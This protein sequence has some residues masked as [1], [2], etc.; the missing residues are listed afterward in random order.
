VLGKLLVLFITIPLLEMLILIKMGEAFGFW[1]TV[2]LVIVTGFI[3]AVLARIE[4][5]RTWLAIR[6]ELRE[7][8]L[9]AEKMMDAL[10]LFVAGVLLITPGVLTDIAGF[11]LLIPATRVLFKRWLRKQFD[12]L[13][14]PPR[15]GGFTD[16]PFFIR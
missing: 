2:A 13:R 12:K 15:G 7:N 3:G 5:F 11:L 14:Y 16:A 8:R 4:G 10:L 6:A 9:P 1:T